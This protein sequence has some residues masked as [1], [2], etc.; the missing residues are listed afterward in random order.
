M[1]SKTTKTTKKSAPT[2]TA[3]GTR[4]AL[5]QPINGLANAALKKAAKAAI[6]P[7]RNRASGATIAILDN[8][9]GQVRKGEAPWLVVCLE[10]GTLLPAQT[11]TAATFYRAPAAQWC[12]GCKA[13]AAERA[14][15]TKKTPAKRPAKAAAKKAPAKPAKTK[16]A[17]APSKAQVEGTIRDILAS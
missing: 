11:L 12:P 5:P 14:K 17:Q 2:W 7:N 13:A 15:A 10:H 4:K 3:A 16:P 8:R 9:E 6:Y 1:A